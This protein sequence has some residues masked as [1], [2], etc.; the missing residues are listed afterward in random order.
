MSLLF[1]SIQTGGQIGV[2]LHQ[3]YGINFSASV[4]VFDALK[5]SGM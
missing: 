2:D 3:Q 5:Y 1:N 4:P